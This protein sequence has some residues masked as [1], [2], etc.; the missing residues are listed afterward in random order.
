M[1][2]R[3]MILGVGIPFLFTLLLVQLSMAVEFPGPL[4]STQFVAENL[5][6]IKN[7][8]Q[9]QIRLVEISFKDGYEKG[10]I[11]GAVNLKGY[12]TNSEIYDPESDHMVP[13]QNYMETIM[14]KL[15]VTDKTHI[16][17]YAR[18]NIVF[19]TRFFW[20]LKYWNIEN[21][22]IMD[23]TVNKW[24]AEKREL[25]SNL[26]KIKELP[27]SVSYPPNQKI[28][29]RLTPEVFEAMLNPDKFLIADTRPAPYFTGEKYSTNKWARSGHIPR[30]IMLAS[31]EETN[32]EDGTFK[33]KEELKALFDK[34]E[35][36]KGKTVVIYC[37][38]G[39]RATGLWFALHELLGYKETKVYD[40][41]MREYANRLDLPI[42]PPNL[43]TNFP[44]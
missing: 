40:G 35:V 37:D 28:R 18:E 21:I 3:K 29:A 15:G 33:S 25:T 6:I 39:V 13:T 1:K 34:K 27:Y 2:V 44:R 19:A 30:A 41:S 43:H 23:G 7:P 16:I 26:P 12:L 24:I 11:P 17:V 42:E 31:P 8:N 32:N 20:T 5:G 14:K 36:M 4:V 38:T 22:H 9:T 10:H